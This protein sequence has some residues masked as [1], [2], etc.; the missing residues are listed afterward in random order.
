MLKK[1][2]CSI[3]CATG[4][5]SGARLSD[6]SSCRPARPTNVDAAHLPWDTSAFLA[7]PVKPHSSAGPKNTGRAI[8]ISAKLVRNA[9]TG[10][11]SSGR[12]ARRQ[13]RLS[14]CSATSM[15]AWMAKKTNQRH[16]MMRAMYQKMRMCQAAEN[17]KVACGNNNVIETRVCAAV[18]L[19]SGQSARQLWPCISALLFH[20]RCKGLPTSTG[21][22]ANT[23]KQ[24]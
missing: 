3:Q 23:P 7:R 22:N 17:R 15:G 9:A 18:G 2:V 16:S 4:D 14:F 10:R 6:A 1:K 13:A 11:G 20:V 24:Y 8:T 12:P 5:A 19:R 21:N